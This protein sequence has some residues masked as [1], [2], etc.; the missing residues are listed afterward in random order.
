MPFPEINA[1]VGPVIDFFFT[2]KSR[3]LF[4]FMFGISF[5]IQLKSAEYHKKPFK[6]AFFWRLTVLMI[7]GLLHGHL[8]FSAD[9]LRYYAAGGLLLLLVYKWFEH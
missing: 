5:F 9:I 1:I 7:F 2:D 4:A 6:R 8:L 3:T